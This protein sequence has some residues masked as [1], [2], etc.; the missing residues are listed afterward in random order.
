MD[1][2]FQNSYEEYGQL[3]T[4]SG[5]SKDLKLNWLPLPKKYIPLAKTKSLGHSSRETSPLLKNISF[6]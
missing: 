4:S 6:V 5:K 3:Q 2:W 1:S